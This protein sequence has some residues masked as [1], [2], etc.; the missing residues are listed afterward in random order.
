MLRILDRVISRRRWGALLGLVAAGASG[1]VGL[2]SCGGGGRSSTTVEPVRRATVTETVDAPATVAPKAQGSVAATADGSVTEL[3]VR[4]G[5]QVRVGQVLLRVASPTATRQLR[6][7]KAADAAAARPPAATTGPLAGAGAG[8]AF[9]VAR[10]QQQLATA[11]T[12]AARALDG[13]DAAARQLPAGRLRAQA[14]SGV[15]QLRAQLATSQAA[16]E[17]ALAQVGSGVSAATG[18]LAQ[19]GG[20]L[21]TAVAA[22]GTAQRAQTR[23]AVRVAQSAVDGLVVRAPV[24]GTVQLGTGAPAA[25]AAAGGG[26]DLGAL[27]AQLPASVSGSLGGRGGATAGAPAAPGGPTSTAPV[28]EGSPVRAGGLLATVFDTSTLMLDADVDETDV[29]AVRPGVEADVQ[30]DAV[31]GAH[32]RGRVTSV[33][34]SAGSSA[35][36]GV[37]YRVHLSIGAGGRADG[38]P[39]PTPRPGMSAV[40]SLA[41][42]TDSNALALPAAAVVRDGERDTVWVRVA[43]R[44]VR[45]PVVLGARGEDTVAV[46]SGVA[47]GDPVVTRG[48]DAVRAGQAVG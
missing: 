7:A 28:T 11:M 44:S 12:A 40:A 21:Q 39:T 25:A 20:Q 23:A 13:A 22:L 6:E 15:A 45:R 29:L 8:P 14:H 41:V 32:Y 1:S 2:A 30:L 37:S 43:G 47:E 24:A 35:R 27:L 46:E 42:R 3:R 26:V 33:E 34:S 5:Q 48:A 38:R 19:V 4:D 16:A 36:G 9:D 18:Q 10:V 31:P 17:G